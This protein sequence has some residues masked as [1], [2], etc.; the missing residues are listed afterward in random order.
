M[1]ALVLVCIGAATGAQEEYLV[2][3]PLAGVKLP[4]FKG[5]H[6]EPTGYPGGTPELQE[7][8]KGTL[9]TG[10]DG[11]VFPEME[12]YPGAEE[13]WRGYYLKYIPQ[14]S[15]FDRQSQI[16]NFTA[17]EIP[18]AG[19][20]DVEK[21]ASPV[22]Y[23]ARHSAIRD[24]GKT[25]AP[26][27]VV[28]LKVGKPV[29]SLDLGTLDVGLYVV[30]VIG[31]VAP[32]DMKAFRK[33]I[34]MRCA[35][36]DGLKGETTEYKL[37]IGYCEE[38]YKVAEFYFHA[39]EERAYKA[40]LAMDA[41]SE[42]DLLVRNV[43][44]DDVLTGIV[45]KA[46]K[47]SSDVPA[48]QQVKPPTITGE[49]R[50]ARDEALWNFLPPP[51][52]QGGAGD[53]SPYAGPTPWYVT[54]G[55]RD[56]DGKFLNMKELDASIGNW[57]SPKLWERGKNG[58]R[59]TS[60][61]SQWGIFLVHPKL[62]LKY[63]IADMKAYKPLPDPYPYKDNGT[64]LYYAEAFK[65][66]T[67]TVD[68]GRILAV[69]AMAIKGRI[70]GASGAGA[71][72][73]WLK[74]GDSDAARDAAVLLA[75][76]AYL[77]PTLDPA[78]MLCVLSK[79][80]VREPFRNS[81]DRRKETIAFFLGHYGGYLGAPNTYNQLFSYIKGNEE[82][83]K[84]INRFVPWV[85]TSQDLIQLFDTY[86]VQMTAK[87]VLRYHYYCHTMALLDLAGIL[88]DPEV[89]APWWDWMFKGAH[90]Y[91]MKPAGIQDIMIVGNDRNGAQYLGS[92]Y[93]QC[94]EGA[95]VVAKSLYPFKVKGQ[96]PAKYD[97]TDP[98]LYPKPLAHCWWQIGIQIAGTEF[99]RI[100]DVTGP[101]KGPGYL[102]VNT[103][104]AGNGWR[105]SGDPAFAW[106][107]KNL[108]KTADKQ[109]EFSA[110]EWAKIEA[111]AATVKRAPWLENKS[112]QVYNAAS[113]LEAGT[114]HDD[115]ALRRAAYLRTGVGKGHQHTDTL[116][117]QYCMLGQQMTIDG[118]QRANYS[119]P[120]DYDAKVHNVVL[121]DGGYG[122]VQSWA[123][124]ISDGTGARYLRATAMLAK[125]F[126][127]AIALV[128]ADTTPET[129]YVL[130][131]VRV[132]GGTNDHTYCFHGPT[133]GDVIC[134]T[135]MKPVPQLAEGAERTP[136]QEF[137]KGWNDAGGMTNA[138]FA[139]TAPAVLE[140][141]W[142]NAGKYTRLHLFDVAGAR[143][144]RADVI[145]FAAKY[146]FAQQMVRKDAG[147]K[148]MS[149][150]FVALHE[151]YKSEPFIAERKLL[152]VKQNDADARK[153]V[154]VEVKLK[155]GRT[156]V[157]FS[158]GYPEKTRE[159]GGIQAAGEF[160]CYSTDEDGVRL[161][162]LTGG[163]LLK[164]PGIEVQAAAREYTGKVTAADYLKKQM[165][166]DAAWPGAC[167][168]GVF[169]IG[170]PSRTTS[171]TLA[172]AKPG[173]K[174]TVL[175]VTEGAD[176]YRSPIMSVDEKEGVVETVI[177]PVLGKMAGLDKDFTVS[178]DARTK[179]WRA[180]MMDRVPGELT[181][182]QFKVTGAPVTQADFAPENALR[183]WEYGVG[184][185]VRHSTFVNVR[186]LPAGGAAGTRYEVMGNVD[187]TITLQ[188]KPAKTISAAEFAKANGKVEIAMP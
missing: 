74:E 113:I 78:W 104:A 98:A 138:R 27:D 52:H 81:F 68:G 100:G 145:C 38:F 85:K 75:R 18:G 86:L 32:A 171:Y 151:P 115:P 60:D 126:N 31:A 77:F 7:K 67:N 153:A 95:V 143:V 159:F 184:D 51:N 157:L 56:K 62:N 182:T 183:L 166:I 69:Q 132:W 49:E 161:A 169:E 111:A 70:A 11:N 13:H 97:L 2:G 135:E 17:P 156:D 19:K 120:A 136:D 50:L 58:D 30:R 163:T 173:D 12:L 168:G 10:D 140:T 37:R 24:T 94:N 25:R 118:G 139:G 122:R 109:N 165:T 177:A 164:A 125:S 124:V 46:S 47:K 55:V 92:M 114:E 5:Q 35:V 108:Y 123:S 119:T 144:Y 39:P 61:R 45:R 63:T 88:D 147:G 82:L 187:A 179:F 90:V 130:D 131:V 14:R 167:P 9:F 89:T 96:L 175:T 106:C 36:N 4:L 137:L 93:Y 181:R 44:L 43:S 188:G 103:H 186:R 180:E 142:R 42:V 117:L 185:S 6:G 154:A 160:A 87:R 91:P 76:Y 65:E 48:P 170:T 71:G 22:F 26:V 64:G 40:E 110:E 20:G 8:A 121:V 54:W 152:E 79:D 155:S 176:Y 73:A 1:T 149:S 107:L 174:S 116:D 158:D 23:V 148:E 102:A 112:R 59:F 178:N 129:S 84:S 172:S 134:N 105:W 15:F 99:P 41:G 16:K 141:T 150:A 146:K 66:G 53:S 3:G 133:G 83:A 72:E 128:D 34:Y 101:D 21:Y 162:S 29:M 127:R 28:R 57:Q 80:P 33:P